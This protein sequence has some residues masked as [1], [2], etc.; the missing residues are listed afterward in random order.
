MGFCICFIYILAHLINIFLPF[1]F[2]E[3][4]VNLF[5]VSII[6]VVTLFF[7]IV[8]Q[9]LSLLTSLAA[10]ATIT[11]DNVS[12]FESRVFYV[13]GYI[14]SYKCQ[15]GFCNTQFNPIY[16]ILFSSIRLYFFVFE[17]VELQ[18]SIFKCIFYIKNSQDVI[19]PILGFQFNI[20]LLI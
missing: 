14:T 9:L 15:Q 2:N 4:E 7:F 8:S 6:A 3:N 12:S 19:I 20:S 10:V 5:F 18:I 17:G 13:L 11:V 16:P 1:R